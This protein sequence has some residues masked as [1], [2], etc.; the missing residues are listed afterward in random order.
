MLALDWFWD[1]PDSWGVSGRLK[2]SKE[3]KFPKAKIALKDPR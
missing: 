3:A 1:I 2:G